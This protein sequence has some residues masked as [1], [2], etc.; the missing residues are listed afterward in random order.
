MTQPARTMEQV[1]ETVATALEVIGHGNPEFIR[2][3]RAGEQ[4]DG[5]FMVGAIA[6][7]R[8]AGA[9]ISTGKE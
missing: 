5:P 9:E 6:E 1:R 8:A 4:D 2:Q 7:W 3:I